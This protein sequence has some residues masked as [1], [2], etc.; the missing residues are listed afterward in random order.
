[1]EL[2]QLLIKKLTIL[3]IPEKSAKTVTFH[4][5]RNLITGENDV[6]KSSIIKS[7]YHSLGADV[8]FDNIW[9]KADA[10]S[11]LTFSYSNKDYMILRSRDHFGLFDEY[12]NLLQS[13]DSIIKGL[14]PYFA[15]LFNNKLQLKQSQTNQR[16][17][18]SPAIQFLPFYIDQ[19]KSWTKPWDSF[20]GLGVFS[21]F[22]R[23][24]I[25]F[26]TGIRSNEYFLLSE[27]IDQ[28][29]AKLKTLKNESGVLSSARKT[30][31]KHIP[32][33]TFDIDIKA[34]KRDIDRLLVKLE[35]LK[36]KENE[37]RKNLIKQ[38]S[39]EAF[40][41]NEIT[42]VSKSIREINKDYEHSLNELDCEITC[43]TCNASYENSMVSRFGLLKDIDTCRSLLSDYLEDKKKITKEV[44]KLESQ[45]NLQV[46]KVREITAILNKKK[47]KVRLKD[48]IQN[49]SSKQ[50]KEIF[51]RSQ[52]NY[53]TQ[54]GGVEEQKTELESARSNL[55]NRERKD[56]IVSRFNTLIDL[57]LIKLN[58]HT[59]NSDG[60][61]D[62]PLSVRSQG[63]DTP[64]ALLAYYYSVL[65]TSKEFTSLPLFPLV[66]DS[67]NQQ[68]Q[69]AT[70][71]HK[72]IKF[73]FENTPDDYQLILGTVDLHGVEYDGHIISP[74]TKLKLLDKDEF[75][76]SYAEIAPLI[77]RL[78]TSL[79]TGS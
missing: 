3:S 63:S 42:L 20:E 11:L 58:V 57:F 28:L 8:Q 67:P 61:S 18:A 46:A 51:N 53:S 77:D 49:E 17:P 44:T 25:N 37:Y 66:I 4:P 60:F 10:I 59:L 56:S 16:I 73:I 14:S 7:I 30:V 69:D 15:K 79:V 31:E 5:Q 68:D 36:N 76:D 13:F 24:L 62:I 55:N 75:E 2:N 6:G 78:Q 1:M 19:D 70:N 64:R 34:F 38:K 74:V 52:S 45:L 47:G 48:L 71:R 12:G 21:G 9:E 22:K 72:I 29:S 43:P 26:V 39:K 54:I 41:D 50:V 33:A 35:V 23:D 40:I 32:K 27:Q 65:F